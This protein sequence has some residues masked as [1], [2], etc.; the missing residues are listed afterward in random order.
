LSLTAGA[1]LL[2]WLT[3]VVDDW[4][5]G[6]GFP[7]IIVTFLVAPMGESLLPS[8]RQRIEAGDRILLPLG[9]AAVAVAAVT[10]LAGGRPL[11]AHAVPAGEELP[12]PSSSVYPVLA[13]FSILHIPASLS[14]AFGIDLLPDV[15]AT[16]TWTRR[17]VQAGLAAVLCVFV[18]WLFNR[19]R[20]LAEAWR[21]IGAAAADDA[22]IEGRVRGAFGRSLAW[23][24]AVCWALLGAEWICADARLSVNVVNL[25]VIACVVADVAG[26][27]QFRFRHGVVT[28]VWP[29]HHLYVLP[30]MLEALDAAGIPAFPSS[31]RLRTLWNFFAVVVPVEILV[32]VAYAGRADAILRPLSGS[33]RP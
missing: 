24:I 22:R 17:G 8:V 15:F 10:R 28:G 1:F 20:A 2:L 27:L 26:E 12:I 5:V 7:L 32:P 30:G 25:T 33:A 18:A 21:R 3:R 16:E 9:L 23:S 11:R 31:R 29:V 14:S 13:S 6:N 4:G 19:P